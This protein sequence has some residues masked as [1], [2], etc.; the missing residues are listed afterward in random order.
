MALLEHRL[1]ARPAVGAVDVA[2]EGAVH[3]LR[4]LAQASPLH[5]RAFAA[6]VD[7]FERQG[8]AARV[9]TPVVQLERLFPGARVVLKLETRSPNGTW[10]DRLAP[11]LLDAVTGET[12]R[13][14]GDGALALA[15]A[16]HL[17]KARRPLHVWLPEDVP[18]DFVQ[19]LKGFG[20]QVELT[21]FAEGPEGARR[22]ARVH[23][24]LVSDFAGTFP[25]RVGVWFEI[26]SEFREQA[27]PR[28]LVLGHDTGDAAQAALGLAF[29]RPVLVQ[30]KAAPVLSGASWRPHRLFGLATGQPLQIDPKR[31]AL[32]EVSDE[33]AFQMRRRA[34]NT[35]GVLLSYADAACLVAAERLALGLQTQ[36]TIGVI[37]GESGERYFPIDERFAA[38]EAKS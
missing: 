22:R 4:I 8:Y 13:E 23:G 2:C 14:A 21:P 6:A 33:E 24:P 3:Q 27:A 10:Y 19:A 7:P 32:A 15:L 25:L 18:V 5:T 1:N 36:L 12:L 9:A 17:P 37:A 29:D 11:R 30:P 26:L 20:A 34:A 31:F 35:E 38:A 28:L 16:A